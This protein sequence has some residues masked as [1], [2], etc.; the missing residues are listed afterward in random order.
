MKLKAARRMPLAVLLLVSAGAIGYGLW[1]GVLP[2]SLLLDYHHALQGY[3]EEALFR[4]ALVY[5]LCFALVVSLA[6]PGGTVMSLAGGYLFGPLFG[7]GLAIIGATL[8]A[9]LTLAVVNTSFG[10]EMQRLS[11]GYF[12]RI[13]RA[14]FRAPVR[15]L[16][17]LRLVP[18]F[19]FFAVN[20]AL[21]LLGV[22][23]FTFT[24]TT[25]LGLVPTTLAF[26]LIGHGMDE[27]LERGR[28]PG[29]EMLFEPVFL[30]PFAALAILLLF[31]FL[32]RRWL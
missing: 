21:A 11:E 7:T 8:G 24:W 27:Q 26:T 5:L 31:G 28:L 17:L 23:L 4:T 1:Q 15:Y 22:R 19:P 12:T 3:A 13:R 25:I 18:V 14:F 30:V 6:L 32:L 29:R 2:E 10:E 20:I 16:L 9:V